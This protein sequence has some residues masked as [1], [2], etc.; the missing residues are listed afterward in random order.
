MSDT[1]TVTGNIATEPDY[2]RT[3]AGITIT[4]FRVASSQRRFDR[5]SGT[6]VDGVT[7][8]YSV[9]TFRRLAEHAFASFK[10]GDRVLLTGRLRLREW[11]N[12][13]RRGTSAEIDAEAI[14]HDLLWGTT[15]FVR[16]APSAS[17]PR[18]DA[19][20][21]E[22]WPAAVAAA[23]SAD[24]P[25]DPHRADPHHAA[26]AWAV[27]GAVSGEARSDLSGDLHAERHIL[28]AGADVPF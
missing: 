16:A 10:K 17:A 22:E 18:S 24:G 2:K 19:P 14:G 20:G 9:S 3:P 13:T 7:N 1:I 23:Q 27:P 8:Y 26:D 11:D 25:L 4:S 21:T 12:G 15:T 28:V 5:N 6:W